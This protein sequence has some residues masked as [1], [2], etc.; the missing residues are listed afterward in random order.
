MHKIFKYSVLFIMGMLL[1]NCGQSNTSKNG[2]ASENMHKAI[3]EKPNIIYILADDL[4]Y[5]DLGCYGQKKIKTPYIDKL[6]SEGML[7][8][9]HYSGN[10]VC[11]PSRSALLTGMHT[12]H[13]FIRGNKEVEPEGQYPLPDSTYTLAKAMKK[14]GYVTGA[15]GKWGLGFPSSE[16]DPTN[17]GFDF[18]YGYNCQ[19]EAHHYYPNH[20]WNN[21]DSIILTEN[22]NKE[23]QI[24][25]PYKIQEETL[26]F[27]DK[28]KDKPF[29]L[30][31]P[32]VLPH[33]ELAAPKAVMEKYKDKFLPEKVYKEGYYSGQ[34]EPHAAFAAMIEIL[35]QQV[36]E[37]VKKVE[38]LGISNNTIIIFTSD[39]GPHQEGGADPEYFDSNGDLRG[40]K[41]DLYE[42]GIRVPM[43][44]KWPG[45]VK[46]NS[47]TRHISAFWDVL[48][49]LS[50]IAKVDTPKNTDGISFLPTLLDKA[51]TQKQHDYL[52]WEFHEMGGKQALR[53]G[54]WK[55]V[56]NGL[57]ENRN[58]P[59]E[60]YNLEL[61]I[62]E[63]DNVANDNQF[64]IDEMEEL[65][66]KARTPSELFSF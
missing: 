3:L 55:A 26:N 19:R 14:A 9:Q 25:A 35:D 40:Y 31:V 5:G 58:A 18:F 28:N 22:K 38:S 1:I 65:F 7:F 6:A 12:G 51:K 39:N 27:I 41:R 50:A 56:K 30:F 34:N 29:F 54:K 44:V 43:I 64:I 45:K 24:Y 8:T 36:G 42:G 66:A 17:Q 53:K 2:N 60:L 13:T 11:A 63:E 23:K 57:F 4:G 61:D 49:T 62:S 32:S 10:T 46:P 16:G 37:I 59:I 21:G 47:K 20:L 48:P 33:A 52:Y 15:Y